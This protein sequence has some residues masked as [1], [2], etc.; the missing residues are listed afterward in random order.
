MS[1]RGRLSKWISG[2]AAEQDLRDEVDFHIGQRA[3]SHANAGL[4][5]SEAVA[6]ARKQFGDMEAVMSDMRRARL[7]SSRTLLALTSA[8]V[9]GAGVWMYVGTRVVLPVLPGPPIQ[10]E[11]KVPPPPPPPPPTWEEFVKKVNTFG[12]GESKRVTESKRVAESGKSR[13]SR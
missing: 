2:P 7:R 11:K 8:A 5:P 13:Q 6:L 9:L 10:T 3:E 1:M 12:V 4:T